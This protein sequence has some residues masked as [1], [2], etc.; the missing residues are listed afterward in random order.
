MG[1]HSRGLLTFRLAVVIRNP[2][3]R[4][5]VLLVLRQK[6][7]QKRKLNYFGGIPTRMTTSCVFLLFASVT[8]VRKHKLAKYALSKRYGGVF[9]NVTLYFNILHF[10][11][12]KIKYFY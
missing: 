8:V 5:Q 7:K 10:L 9:Q 2:G 11:Y 4:F 6:L 3:D 1:V 12:H